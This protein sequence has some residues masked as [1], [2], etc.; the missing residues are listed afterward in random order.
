MTLNKRYRSKIHHLIASPLKLS[1]QKRIK[2]TANLIVFTGRSINVFK[3]AR[4]ALTSDEKIIIFMAL[5]HL[6]CMAHLGNGSP[7]V[8]RLKV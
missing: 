4:K 2:L 6:T 1:R 8:M 3:S 5:I 7:I